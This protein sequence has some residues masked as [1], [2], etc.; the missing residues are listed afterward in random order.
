MFSG[1]EPGCTV[2]QEKK[3]IVMTRLFDVPVE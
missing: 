1:G 2:D 3:E